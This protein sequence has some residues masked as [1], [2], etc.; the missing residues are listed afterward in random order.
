[1]IQ[2]SVGLGFEHAINPLLSTVDG[3]SPKKTHPP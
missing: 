2:H 1:M 3:A